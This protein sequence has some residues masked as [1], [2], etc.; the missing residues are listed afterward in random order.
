MSYRVS[1]KD[2]K[3][4][5]TLRRCAE[6]AASWH[7]S[8]TRVVANT[9]AKAPMADVLR[10]QLRRWQLDG[11]EVIGRVDIDNG[12]SIYI[13]NLPEA[14]V[15]TDVNTL[16]IPAERAERLRLWGRPRAEYRRDVLMVRHLVVAGWQ[17]QD[18]NDEFDNRAPEGRTPGAKPGRLPDALLAN[19]ETL[20]AAATSAA[21]QALAQL[22]AG[23]PVRDDLAVIQEWNDALA[24]AARE[25][26]L[27][28]AG[29]GLDDVRAA[30]SRRQQA[31][32]ARFEEVLARCEALAGLDGL[33]AAGGR[34]AAPLAAMREGLAGSAREAIGECL[35]AECYDRLGSWNDVQAVRLAAE[36]LAG[37]YVAALSQTEVF[38]PEQLL[39]D[40]GADLQVRDVFRGTLGRIDRMRLARTLVPT[41]CFAS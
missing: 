4:I 34:G 40:L 2:Q 28:G 9:D 32:Q 18:S 36:E 6:Q 13:A 21:E 17:V 22:A 1:P 25:L 20:H 23:M 16:L 38:D 39:E 37:R 7:G 30:L 14:I 29:I 33:I 15:L 31:A 19:L 24:G 3:V 41:A 35:V 26:D 12:Q 10:R 8:P 27:P 11:S 5:D